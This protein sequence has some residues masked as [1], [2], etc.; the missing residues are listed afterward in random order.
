MVYYVYSLNTIYTISQQ[1]NAI[2]NFRYCQFESTHIF[3]THTR[4]LSNARMD[5][6]CVR[7]C[8]VMGIISIYIYIR[9]NTRSNIHN[10]IDEPLYWIEQRLMG[11]VKVAYMMSW[12][13]EISQHVR[14]WASTYK[15]K[16]LYLCG[17]KVA[18]F[19]PF[20]I[21]FNSIV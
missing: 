1:S 13:C 20:L 14:W 17:I 5:W 19:N 7:N 11:N 2:M 10:E 6:I 3:L 16:K 15:K 4:S 12:C 21:N 18:K 8:G 9:S